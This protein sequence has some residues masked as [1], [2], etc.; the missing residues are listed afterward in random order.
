MGGYP[1]LGFRVFPINLSIYSLYNFASGNYD[2]LCHGCTSLGTV[3]TIPPFSS[4]VPALIHLPSQQF[5]DD[6]A[7]PQQVQNQE[8][9]LFCNCGTQRLSLQTDLS[10]LDSH[11]KLKSEA[12]YGFRI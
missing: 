1:I 9:N 3:F 6:K 12:P 2:A 11:H 7:L 5:E 10:R 4:S 8:R